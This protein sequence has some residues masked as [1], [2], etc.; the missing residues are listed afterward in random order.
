MG[1]IRN[2]MHVFELQTMASLV[3]YSVKRIFF[4]KEMMGSFTLSNNAK[5]KYTQ[6]ERIF[7][8]NYYK[9]EE[10]L[11]WGVEKISNIKKLLSN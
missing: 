6:L 11:N 9:N 8:I 7:Y 5:Y 1:I 4:E 3:F 10:H 2:Y